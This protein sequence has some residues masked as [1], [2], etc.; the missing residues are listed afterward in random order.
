MRCVAVRSRCALAQLHASSVVADTVLGCVRLLRRRGLVAEWKMEHGDNMRTALL[1]ASAPGFAGVL[2][3]TNCAFGGW[4][5]QSMH[6]S[7]L[8]EIAK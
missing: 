1:M 5:R 2:A 4:L 3:G 6:V 7:E 8:L